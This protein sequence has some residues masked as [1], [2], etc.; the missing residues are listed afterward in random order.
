MEEDKTCKN[1]EPEKKEE[2]VYH[3]NDCGGPIY[4]HQVFCD[5]CGKVADTKVIDSYYKQNPAAIIISIV[6]G[7]VIAFGLLFI[8]AQCIKR[9]KNKELVLE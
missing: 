9:G 2:R 3:C 7:V 5:K 6:S 8:I 1:T 4:K